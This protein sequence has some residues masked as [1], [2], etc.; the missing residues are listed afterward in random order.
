MRAK[1]LELLPAGDARSRGIRGDT[2]EEP[3]VGGLK[4]S[5]EKPRLYLPHVRGRADVTVVCIHLLEDSRAR[6]RR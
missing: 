1:F 4:G 3:G 2:G 5:M 6:V